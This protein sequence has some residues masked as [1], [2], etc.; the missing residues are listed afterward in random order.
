[1]KVVSWLF[2]LL[3]LSLGCSGNLDLEKQNKPPE[4][5]MP[6]K[7]QVPDD[8]PRSPF[9]DIPVPPEREP[10]PGDPNSDVDCDGLADWEEEELG[11]HPKNRDTDGDGIWDGIEMGRSFSVDPLCRNYFPS[12]LLSATGR[13]I[14][15]PLRQDTDCDGISDG[16]EDKNHNGRIDE[17]ETDPTNEDTD[18]D[19]LWDGTELGVTPGMILLGGQMLPRVQQDSTCDSM[20]TRQYAAICPSGIR[21]NI[22]NPLLVDSD[23][24]GIPDG[25]EDANQN[26]CYEPAL[27][28]TNPDDANS[29]NPHTE[30]EVR[31]ACAEENLAKI[32]I[33]RHVPAQIALGLPFSFLDSNRYVDIQRTNTAGITTQGL[34]GLDVLE[35]NV[36][37]LAWRHP[38]TLTSL[39]GLRDLVNE[40]IQR[41][42]GPNL[43]PTIRSFPSWD[44]PS[45]IVGD[46]ALSVLFQL[47]SSPND[48]S[49]AARANNIATTLL[50]QNGTGSLTVSGAAGPT[51]HV[52]AQYVLREGGHVI[53]VMA[54]A[55]DNNSVTGSDGYFGLNDVAGGAALASHLDQTV[56]QCERSVAGHNRVDFLFVVDDSNSMNDSQ[57]NLAAV[58]D[59]MA[60][61]LENS[62]LDWRV[63]MV[64]STYHTTYP[65]GFPWANTG[66][67]RGFTQSTQLFKTWLTLDTNTNPSCGAV[68]A[69]RGEWRSGLPCGRSPYGSYGSYNGCWIGMGGNGYEGMLGAARLAV[70][71]M[72]DRG[73]PALHRFRDNAEIAVIILSDTEDHTS[74]LYSTQENGTSSAPNYNWENV[75]NFIDFFQGNTT[76]D[77]VPGLNPGM[78][79]YVPVG[80]HCPSGGCLAPARP[81]VTISVHAIYCPNWKSNNGCQGATSTGT[82]RIQRVAEATRGS[83]ASITSEAAFRRTIVESIVEG[84]IASAGIRTQK[85]LIGA[86]L[87]VAINNPQGECK[88][89]PNDA[90][91]VNGSHVPRSREHG[92]DYNGIAQTVSF[93][94]NC[95]PPEGETRPVALSY[96]AWETPR[97]RLPCRNDIRFVNDASQGYCRG[98]FTCDRE[99]NMC[100]CL[101][102][103]DDRC[104]QDEY[105]DLTTCS[106]V[107]GTVW[108]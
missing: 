19:G 14:T 13:T 43:A 79:G 37:F 73:A 104:K 64:S 88:T 34:M 38:A 77:R 96:R 87:R 74:G 95:R 86:S 3:L 98:P 71:D 94:G 100:V 66:I 4:E 16:D 8:T 49:P 39:D 47:S 106:C 57:R 54:V 22:T 30:P 45:S 52:R 55:L 69:C 32:D 24:D 46:N 7:V 76:R 2:S 35:R 27:G 40:H 33:R 101:P 97:E 93:F 62:T 105:C 67:I 63:A 85:P 36:A 89:D 59:A 29:P 48:M 65:N 61:A 17:N 6:G 53:V 41:L 81:D 56:V 18:G 12:H 72:S 83:L 82:T 70:M 28:E 108:N 60:T 103:C 58:A 92:F 1:M 75:E 99:R 25:R 10:N 50:G 90:T 44:A 102:A 11:T 9:D 68:T 15:N 23:G 80:P 84:T 20:A 5:Q 91:E 21:R 26:G 78:P 31:F 42:G 51:Q 107:S